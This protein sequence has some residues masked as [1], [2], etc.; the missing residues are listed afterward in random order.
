MYIMLP[1]RQVSVLFTQMYTNYSTM[2]REII[3]RKF[4][5]EFYNSL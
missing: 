4:L 2:Y 1:N 5:F 3:F